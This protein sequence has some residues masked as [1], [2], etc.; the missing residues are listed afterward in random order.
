MSARKNGFLVLLLVLMAA[1]GGSAWMLSGRRSSEEPP[2]IELRE[3]RIVSTRVEEPVETQLTLELPRVH[4]GP[5]QSAVTRPLEVELT[6]LQRGTFAASP[7]LPPP[8]SGANAR[9]KGRIAG[10]RGVGTSGRVTF[11]AGPNAGRVLRTDKEGSF[12]ASDLY[13]GLAVVEL[14]T[15]TG[16]RSVRQITL[17]QLSTEELFVTL[18]REAACAVRGLVKDKKGAP[19]FGAEVFL[20][21]QRTATDD[22]GEFYFPRVSPDRVV[23][24]VKK[25]GYASYME[26]VALPIGG[27]IARENLVFTLHGG[28][29]LELRFEQAIGSSGPALAYV[30]PVGGQRVNS[31]LGQNTFPWHEVN[32]IVIH[33]GG[34]ALIE[35][36]QPG[37]V[38][39][40]IFHPGGKASPPFETKKLL[41]GRTN[42]HA[43]HVQP[44]PTLRGVVQ[45]PDGKPISGATVT[46]EAPDRG[47][48][49]VR[50]MQ[51]KPTFN[52]QMVVPQLPSALQQ[53]KTDKRGNF[54]LTLYPDISSSYY[55]TA[56]DPGGTLRANRVVPAE[57]GEIEVA[58]EPA[59]DETGKLTVRMGG[60]F[61]GLPV[62]V[63]VNGALMD[64]YLLPAEDELEIE[65]LEA[66]TW[67]AEVWW[68]H[69][70]LERG[71]TFVLEP[72][73]SAEIAVVLPE[74]ALEGEP[75]PESETR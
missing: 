6:Q 18:G 74:G 5:A 31:T 40:S 7:E 32:P 48:A 65:G 61:Q 42:H 70:Q 2:A 56:V 11:L 10:D 3:P 59:A 54:A 47:D 23:A 43:F 8:G 41:E 30:F 24:V 38:I 52:L 60:R 19:I 67:R 26:E 27:A 53:V 51:Q 25:R 4:Q 1:G 55:L 35:G 29:D 16:L 71:K 22:Q 17:R 37:H 28:A 64:P 12:G 50:V 44:A 20:D 39:L 62:K 66:G 14:E 75:P 73:G 72:D 46:L 13:Q 33:P 58:L 57:A 21:G 45:G 36:L 69:D 34:T 68:H 15:D 63:S 49:T 9:L